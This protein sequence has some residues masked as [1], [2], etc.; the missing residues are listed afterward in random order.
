MIGGSGV[1]QRFISDFFH[2]GA[3]LATYKGIIEPFGSADIGAWFFVMGEFLL[4][5]AKELTA[6]ANV[7]DIGMMVIDVF[8]EV[9]C[10]NDKIPVSLL[11][12]YKANRVF[13]EVVA[14]VGVRSLLEPESD[15]SLMKGCDALSVRRFLA[16]YDCV[17]LA[18]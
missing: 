1:M 2:G 6:L 14:W 10:Q 3:H 15:F 13:S 9:S 12:V 11:G 16:Y 18:L 4:P 7:L 8:V 5:D 17:V